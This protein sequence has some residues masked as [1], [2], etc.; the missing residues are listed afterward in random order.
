MC[1]AIRECGSQCAMLIRV[2]GP[3]ITGR[4]GG[5]KTSHLF[6]MQISSEMLNFS[7]GFCNL[8]CGAGARPPIFV[9]F[10]KPFD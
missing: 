1:G 2:F 7:N 5:A 3:A 8:F 6:I 9:I 10:L 4:L